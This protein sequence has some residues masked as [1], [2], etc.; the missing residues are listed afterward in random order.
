MKSTREGWKGTGDD[1]KEK[2]ERGEEQWK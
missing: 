1:G 2:G